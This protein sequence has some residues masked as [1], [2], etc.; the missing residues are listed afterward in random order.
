LLKIKI[1]QLTQLVFMILKLIINIKKKN[2][3]YS[4][5]QIKCNAKILLFYQ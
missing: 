3:N 2:S 4:R 1:M 5:T